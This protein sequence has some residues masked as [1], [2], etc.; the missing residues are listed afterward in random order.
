M[1]AER[2]LLETDQSGN[3]IGTPKLPPNSRI[4]AIFLVMPAAGDTNAVSRRPHAD[5]AGRTRILGDI[6]SSAPAEDWN[7]PA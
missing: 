1:Y 2:R 6:T 5:I 3:L 7:Q 4:E